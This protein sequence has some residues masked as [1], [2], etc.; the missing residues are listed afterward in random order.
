MR[1]RV[2]ASRSGGAS[3]SRPATAANESCQPGSPDASGLS[4]SV[5]AAARPSAYQR[6][7]GRPASAATSPAIPI[8]PARW[9]DGPP[10]ASGT[11]TA[12]STAAAISRA[13]NGT[14]S[15]AQTASTSVQSSSTFW[16]DTA[17]RWARPER[18]NSSRTSL[19]IASSCPRTMPRSSAAWGGASPVPSPR[20]ARS[21][22]SS[23]RPSRPPRAPPVGSHETTS[24][25]APAPR[26][27]WYASKS[28]SG[29]TVPRRCSSLPTRTSGRDR[30]SARARRP[31]RRRGRPCGTTPGPRRSGRDPRGGRAPPSCRRSAGA[32]ARAGP[33]A[34]RSSALP[35]TAARRTRSPRR[36]P[37]RAPSPRERPRRRS[38]PAACDRPA[39]PP[40]RR[41]PAR[42][43]ARQARAGARRRPRT[44]RGGAD[45]GGPPRP[46]SQR[47]LLAQRRQPLVADAGDLPELLDR[48]EPPTLLAEVEDLLRR[49]RPDPAQRVEL[50]QRRGVEVERLPL[51]GRCPGRPGGRSGGTAARLAPA[52][53]P[54]ARPPPSRRGSGRRGRHAGWRRP[55]ARRRRP[56]AR[57]TGACRRP[58]SRTAP[59]TWTTT[60][61]PSPA[62]AS[63]CT[64]IVAT[65]RAVA[66]PPSERAPSWR[67]PSTHAST[68]PATQS[69]SWR[70]VR[71]GM[72][73]S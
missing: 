3:A 59:A 19:P 12:T 6:D 30:P 65:G 37:A 69:A 36:A 15:T 21:R 55:R 13:R 1:L 26:R 28:P 45:G 11:Y 32:P 18:R 57:S 72:P 14:S 64:A 33:R 34:R 68:M 56:R 17:R 2:I 5:T 7:D 16:P 58:G 54:A 63:S 20:T 50:L 8:T 52:R 61:A 70:P 24:I 44:A 73:R 38:R 42:R 43:R 67:T 22:A 51:G 25:A 47:Q 48:A 10:P 49:R 4:V 62:A 35:A 31:L 66:A 39:T 46:L 29:A 9:I 71:S 40:R 41:P 53:A 27:R 23:S 60:R